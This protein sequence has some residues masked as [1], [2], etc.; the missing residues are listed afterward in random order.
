MERLLQE[1][2]FKMVDVNKDGKLSFGEFCFA[3]SIMSTLTKD[4]IMY[5][6]FQMFDT[7]GSGFIERDELVALSEAVLSMSEGS[8]K[9]NHATFMENLD[10]NS[11]GMLDFPE[12]MVINDRFPMVFFPAF[13]IQDVLRNA[14]L[15]VSRWKALIARFDRLEA[16]RAKKKGEEPRSLLEQVTELG[17]KTGFHSGIKGRKKKRRKNAAGGAKKAW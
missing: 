13:K 6:I 1:M 8:Y 10:V 3:C 16:A 17:D 2:V 11:D 9:G 12:F 5:I 15:G 4:Q 14:T 7:D